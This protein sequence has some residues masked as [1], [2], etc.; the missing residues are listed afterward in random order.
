M[1]LFNFLFTDKISSIYRVASDGYGAKSKSYLYS[2]LS[3]RF[4]EINAMSYKNSFVKENYKGIFYID[5][6][7]TLLSVEDIIVFNNREYIIKS[8]QMQ[9]PLLGVAQFIKLLVIDHG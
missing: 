9:K 3:C 7:Y 1:P 5:P 2:N 8:I 4:E 6:R